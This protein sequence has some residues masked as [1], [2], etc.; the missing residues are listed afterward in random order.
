MLRVKSFKLSDDAGIN[1]ILSQ[2]RI[3][4]GASVFMSNGEICIPYENGEPEPISHTTISLLEQKN[5]LVGQKRVIETAQLVNK[6]LIEHAQA[7]FDQASADL[8]EA[9]KATG[10]EKYDDKKKAEETLKQVE[11]VLNQTQNTK[12]QN[13][14]E[15]KRLALNIQVIDE[16]VA[17][18]RK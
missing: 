5:I 11:N 9:D 13:D 14:E 17:E 8:A 3:A 1:E 4:Q 2:Y 18:L 12:L 16:Q 7:R 10:K 15:L 6:H